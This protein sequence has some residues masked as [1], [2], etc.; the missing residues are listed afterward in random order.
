M[1]YSFARYLNIRSATAPVFSPTADRVAFLS[2]ITDN[3]QVWSIAVSA[4]D[5]V[6]SAQSAASRDGNWPLQL[7]YLE[8]KVWEIYGTPA[9]PHLLVVSDVGGNERQQFYLISNFGLND[10]GQPV[11]DVR[12]LTKD[13]TAIHRFGAWSRDGRRLAF[14]SNARNGVDFDYYLMDVISGE[15]RLLQ[16]TGGNRQIA[17]WSPNEQEML[18]L[19]AVGSL[20]VELHRFN[21]QTQASQHLT[22]GLEAARYWAI[23]WQKEGIYLLSDRTHDRGALC[24][25]D[26]ESGQLTELFNIERH[27]NLGPLSEFEALAIS[28]SNSALAYT[29]NVN[30]YCQL[31]LATLSGDAFRLVESLPQGVI[32]DLRFSPDGKTLALSLQTPDRNPNIWLVDVA[33][34]QTS[35]LTF[36]N[37]AGI[38][39]RSMVCPQSIQYDTFDERQIP[40]YFYKPQTPAPEGGYP[41]ILYVHGG[42][43]SQVRPDF[44]VRFQYFISQGYAILATNV[45]GSTGYGRQYT[46]LDEIE[47][48]MASVA[49]LKYAV[50]WLRE[51]VEIDA[52]RIA[53]Y[54]RSYGGFMV[55]AALTEYPDLFAAG[56]DVVGI[57]NW[58]TFLERTSAWRR[59]HREQEYGSLSQHRQ[60]LEQ[61][62]PIHKAERIRV[63][64]MVIA[65]DNDPRVPLSESEQIVARVRQ[66]GSTVEFVHYADEG[67]KISKL[68]NRIN[69]FTKMAVFLKRYL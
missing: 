40:A 65:G 15:I 6:P 52:D 43:A 51:Q 28:G 55:L 38:P 66:A 7:T 47:R 1:S 20:Q 69:S 23:S 10:Q 36:S 5:G 14:T 34:A 63:P 22:A 35:Q 58:V 8:H 64:L 62:S 33:S 30:G 56:I 21:L 24:R 48:R 27:T 50:Q 16:E 12:R 61:M 60:V 26:A 9:A 19:E 31:F 29:I 49:D 54:G 13:D 39:Q 4:T 17:A 44:D 68:N 67:H 18:V 53:I 42:P 32:R 41:C 45:R 25:L 2:D 59:A 37:R 3:F 57:S 46:A 11:Y